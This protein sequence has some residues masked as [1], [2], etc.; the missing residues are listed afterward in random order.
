M[1]II[2]GD[3]VC[4]SGNDPGLDRRGRMVEGEWEVRGGSWKRTRQDWVERELAQRHRRNRRLLG[5]V[6]LFGAGVAFLA[7][8]LWLLMV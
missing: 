1:E 5:Y 6:L 3:V 2:E 7:L 4:V 8:V